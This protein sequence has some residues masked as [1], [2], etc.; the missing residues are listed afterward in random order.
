LYGGFGLGNVLAL[1]RVD[2]ER[3]EAGK[4]LASGTDADVAFHEGHKTR[5]IKNG[6]AGK[7]V[8]LES[9]KVEK[10]A[11][12]VGGRK[13]EATLKVSKENNDFTG[14]KHRFGLITWKP[15]GD[16][17]RYSPGPVKPVNL[18]LSHVGTSPGSACDTGKILSGGPARR[19]DLL[20][21]AGF[22]FHPG[23]I[24]G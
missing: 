9:I 8:R 21:F 12:E 7:V 18:M 6:V 16:S 14:F 17:I 2:P 4:R 15:A 22:S 5:K 3:K 10:L 23:E 19:T 13:A 11:E 24:F 1:D 20:V